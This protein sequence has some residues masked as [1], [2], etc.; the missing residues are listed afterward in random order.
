[1]QSRSGGR[2]SLSLTLTLWHCVH[3]T[4]TAVALARTAAAVMMM[5][6]TC[7]KHQQDTAEASR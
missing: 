7:N 5:P 3:C 6:S 4:R 2:C 1:M